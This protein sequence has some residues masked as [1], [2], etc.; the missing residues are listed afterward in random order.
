MPTSQTNIPASCLKAGC[1]GAQAGATTTKQN[2]L[3]NAGGAPGKQAPPAADHSAMAA[4]VAAAFTKGGAGGD[5]AA[6]FNSFKHGLEDVF[7]QYGLAVAAEEEKKRNVPEKVFQLQRQVRTL[8]KQISDLTAAVN[9]LTQ[10]PGNGGG[11]AAAAAAGGNKLLAGA[12][13]WVGPL[14]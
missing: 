1:C 14:Q 11:A 5:T 8:V 12:T 10:N 9:K 2:V 3:P 7:K 13:A 6:P 4:A